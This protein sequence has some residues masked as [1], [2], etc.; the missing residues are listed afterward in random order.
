[1]DP[2]SNSLLGLDLDRCSVTK[3]LSHALHDLG[4][5]VAQT[6]DG[7]STQLLRMLQTKVERVLARFL[8]QVDENG[9]V[10]SD[11][12]LQSLANC[13]DLCTRSHNDAASHLE[14]FNDTVT[15]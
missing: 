6:D 7:I 13:P 15:I 2:R 11:Q 8:T 12:G 10:I 14:I 3:H 1:M 5:V 9:D 4:C